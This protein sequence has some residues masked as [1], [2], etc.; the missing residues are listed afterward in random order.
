[1]W[2]GAHH[3]DHSCVINIGLGA[4]YLHKRDSPG[5]DELHALPFSKH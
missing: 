5:D 1:M 2:G 4:V 3:L